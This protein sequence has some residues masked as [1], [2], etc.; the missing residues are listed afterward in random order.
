MGLLDSYEPPPPKKRSCVVC[1]SGE[2]DDVI[3]L[4]E[5]GVTYLQIA[6]LATENG[7]PMSDQQVGKHCRGECN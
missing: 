3:T 1:N 7:F 5:R 6:R 4:H 2:G